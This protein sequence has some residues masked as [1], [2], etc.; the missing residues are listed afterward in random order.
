MPGLIQLAESILIHPESIRI[1]FTFQTLSRSIIQYEDSLCP[2]SIVSLIAAFENQGVDGTRL[3][4]SSRTHVE[5]CASAR[6]A[7]LAEQPAKRARLADS[8][9][10]AKRAR[11]AEQRAKR[12]QRGAEFPYSLFEHRP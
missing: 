9:E 3:A 2:T 10:P 5:R 8:S 1:H 6:L 7:R 11:L 12:A 4:T